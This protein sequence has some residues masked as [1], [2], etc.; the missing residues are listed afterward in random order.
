MSQMAEKF[1]NILKTRSIDISNSYQNALYQNKLG[2]NRKFM[3]YTMEKF[4]QNTLQS[5]NMNMKICRPYI[6]FAFKMSMN[7]MMKETLIVRM[8]WKSSISS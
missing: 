8:F 3:A 7:K 6:S 5:I 1:K 4:P 2:I